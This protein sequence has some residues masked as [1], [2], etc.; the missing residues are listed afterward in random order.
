MH[1]T[2]EM[3]VQLELWPGDQSHGLGHHGLCHLQ[4]SGNVG[5]SL[6]CCVVLLGSILARLV[7]ALHDVLHKHT[8]FWSAHADHI[9]Q[10]EG[11]EP[12]EAPQ[13]ISLICFCCRALL[14]PVNTEPCL[15]RF[16]NQHRA[17]LAML[18]APLCCSFSNLCAALW[19]PIISSLFGPY[20][21][22][23]KKIAQLMQRHQSTSCN[24]RHR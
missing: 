22:F 23:A 5:T 14:S 7:D 24:S 3:K 8:Y 4:E 10:P 1:C 15:E 21:I 12:V 18:C 13:Q 20:S 9:A 6:Q 17:I 16:I 19:C 11:R 2:A